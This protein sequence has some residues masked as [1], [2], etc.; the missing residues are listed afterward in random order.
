MNG[1]NR[2]M[3]RRLVDICMTVLLL[4]LMA[5]Q[6]TGE[7]AHEWIG[8]AM[9]ALVIVHQILNRKWY[10][11]IFRGKYNAYRILATTVDI[12]LLLSF[13]MTAFCGMSMSGYAV[14]FLYGMAKVSFVRR[15]HLSMSHWAFI[16]MGLHLGLHIP[17]MTAKWKLSDKNKNLISAVFCCAA[18]FGL[19]FFLQNK[20]P[21]YIFFRM[22]FAFFDYDKS[23]ILVFV[24][25]LAMMVFWAFLGAQGASLCRK[26]HG[27]T[28]SKKNPLLPAVYMM[29][30]VILGL[31]LS[32]TLS[33]GNDQR[34]GDTN[35][36]ASQET[37]PQEAAPKED[38]GTAPADK[39]E[40]PS[41]TDRGDLPLE[42]AQEEY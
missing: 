11:A 32:M 17:V 21:D 37:V 34:F 41:E 5:Y 42:T 20:M 27:G 38:E 3:V 18:G 8:I 6:V 9:T 23:P 29:A 14:P 2:M 26:V 36:N 19:F 30:A 10:G 28:A 7:V 22:H 33:S 12:L 25:N 16:L 15:M 39:E 4:C 35:W 40:I 24:E 31:A 13:V 1:K